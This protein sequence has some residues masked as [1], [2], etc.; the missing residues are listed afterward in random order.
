M[1]DVYN[2]S[3]VSNATNAT[4]TSCGLQYEV[5]SVLFNDDGI[6]VKGEEINQ[7]FEVG[8]I[9]CLGEKHVICLKLKGKT[10]KVEVKQ[11]LTVKSKIKC[12]VCGK[13]NKSNHKFCSR[14]G[15]NLKF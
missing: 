7:K 5:N 9:G 8:S 13:A 10:E 6:T 2:V 14:C 15:N 11:P 3:N 12:S 4:N 1:H